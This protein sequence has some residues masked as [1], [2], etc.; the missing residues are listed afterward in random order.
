M[1]G[2][3]TLRHSVGTEMRSARGAIEGASILV[4]TVQENLACSMRRNKSNNT[5]CFCVFLCC[6]QEH[7]PQVTL[8]GQEETGNASRD[9]CPLE[10]F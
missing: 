9:L 6:P 3:G 8:A 5:R 7:G 10:P 1:S 2:Q 4:T